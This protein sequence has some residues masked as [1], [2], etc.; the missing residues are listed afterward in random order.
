MG[1]DATKPVFGVSDK[2]RLNQFR[3]L[4]KLAR[5]IT[6]SKF[7]YDTFQQGNNKGGSVCVDV[8]TGL[9]FVVADPE[10]RFS[11]V[12]ALNV[13]SISGNSCNTKR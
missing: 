10:D 12:E 9:C 2:V 5:N 6:C 8:Q 4:Q 3:Q 1:F 7:R 11:H 13:N